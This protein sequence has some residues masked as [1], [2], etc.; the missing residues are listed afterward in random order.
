MNQRTLEDMW[1]SAPQNALVYVSCVF[2]IYIL[3]LAITIMY[4]TYKVGY[5]ELIKEA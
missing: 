1:A 5:Q 4:E 3:A 2:V